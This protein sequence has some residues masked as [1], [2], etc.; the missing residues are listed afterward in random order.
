MEIFWNG[1]GYDKDGKFEFEINDGK[2]SIK[3]YYY[4]GILRFEGD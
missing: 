3:E 4:N 1:Y 2:G